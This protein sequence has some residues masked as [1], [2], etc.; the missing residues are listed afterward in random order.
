MKEIIVD[1]ARC[2]G[3]K[4]CELQC[5]LMRDSLSQ[6]FPQAIYEPVAPA[7]RVMVEAL[8]KKGSFPVQ[9]R[10]CTDAPCLDACPSG[11]LY[12]G[13][14]EA[15]LYAEPRCIGCWMCVMVCPFGA[16]AP[17]RTAKKVMKCDRCTGMEEPYCVAA[18]PTSALLFVEA[19]ELPAKIRADLR[20]RLLDV[21]TDGRTVRL[22]ITLAP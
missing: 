6:K 22:D 11:A 5:A 18:C 19:A 8:G 12:R 1:V 9:C 21:L 15:V 4:S 17:R 20:G 16:V 10:H 2:V 3:C 13:D 14:Q 7:P